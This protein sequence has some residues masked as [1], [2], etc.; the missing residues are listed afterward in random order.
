[1]L[2]DVTSD[3]GGRA[4]AVFTLRGGSGAGDT[5][6][7]GWLAIHHRFPGRTTYPWKHGRSTLCC[8]LR[9]RQWSG[10][11][12]GGWC[13]G[14]GLAWSRCR[15]VG[16]G[17]TLGSVRSAQTRLNPGGLRLG[18]VKVCRL[19]SRGALG[20]REVG[21]VEILWDWSVT[22]SAVP[23]A[24]S[25]VARGHGSEAAVLRS[26]M[27]RLERQGSAATPSARWWVP[28]AGG[29]RPSTRQPVRLRVSWPA[30]CG[31]ASPCAHRYLRSGTGCRALAPRVRRR[32][33]E[34]AV[35]RVAFGRTGAP[36]AEPQ[37]LAPTGVEW[38]GRQLPTSLEAE[39]GQAG[40]G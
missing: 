40:S 2:F 10:P 25:A 37:A 16:A 35:N 39:G 33:V 13:C 9:T 7:G 30:V 27:T 20:L 19:V 22:R 11:S 4:H 1:M 26:P 31:A 12:R 14:I 36:R 34:H 38:H 8:F 21:D 32:V 24:A 29:E 15:G 5:G 23:Q 3:G 18:A 28:R 6:R 17:S